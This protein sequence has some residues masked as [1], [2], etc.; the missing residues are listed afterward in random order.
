MGRKVADDR[1]RRFMGIVP[2]VACEEDIGGT[3]RQLVDGGTIY[4][5][6]G[7]LFSSGPIAGRCIG[8][9]SFC[10]G[11]FN[12]IFICRLV[13]EKK[14]TERLFSVLL[15]RLNVPVGLDCSALVTV[16]WVEPVTSKA[17]AAALVS[18]ACAGAA[19][20]GRTLARRARA[21]ARSALM[22]F[23]PNLRMDAAPFRA[24]QRHEKQTHGGRGSSTHGM[25][26]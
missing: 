19:P 3:W 12:T 24:A 7:N 13:R 17:P 11:N 4:C 25:R 21:R 5:A 20:R 18:S 22:H 26:L 9:R 8:S 10:I 14:F 15:I 2:F 16:S 6:V 23:L 1:W